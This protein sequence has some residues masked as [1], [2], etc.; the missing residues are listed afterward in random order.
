MASRERSNLHF[1]E[2]SQVAW[3]K[4]EK[5]RAIRSMKPISELI[6]YPSKETCVGYKIVLMV[7]WIGQMCRVCP[8]EVM[9]QF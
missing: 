6:M 8:A 1:F 5:L 9:A 3:N 4:I 2:I 7:C